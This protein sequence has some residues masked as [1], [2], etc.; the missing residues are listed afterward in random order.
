MKFSAASFEKQSY[1]AQ[2]DA[3]TGE[4]LE[5]Q[6]RIKLLSEAVAYTGNE[7]RTPY[8]TRR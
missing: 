2:I 1:A 4:Y 7:I 3:L 6:V 5:L 8:S